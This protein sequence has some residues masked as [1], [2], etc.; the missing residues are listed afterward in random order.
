[1]KSRA[2]KFLIAAASAAAISAC[3]GKQEEDMAALV[4][5]CWDTALEQSMMLAENT[6]SQEGRLPRTYEDGKL[7]TADYHNWISGFFPER[8]G[9]CTSTGPKTGNSGNTPRNTPGG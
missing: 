9:N 8:F 5:R 4:D 3:G 1:M 7:F 6:L 2:Y